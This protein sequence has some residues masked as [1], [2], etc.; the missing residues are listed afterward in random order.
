[1]AIR[2]SRRPR[3][4]EFLYDQSV[5]SPPPAV[6][7]RGDV[8]ELPEPLA[9]KLRDQGYGRLT[10]DVLETKDLEVTPD[11]PL[12]PVDDQIVQKLVAAGFARADEIN[13]ACEKIVK[14]LMKE[15]VTQDD[16]AKIQKKKETKNGRT[17][18]TRKPTDEK[19][20]DSGPDIQGGDKPEAKA[21]PHRRRRKGVDSST[22]S[23]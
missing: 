20:S 12:K 18:E 16:V 11:E 15:Y 5:H 9:I 22:V 14:R 21:V 23:E 6:G 3:L 1:M 2:H 13:S 4:V 10:S 7:K 17:E 19:Q 8:K